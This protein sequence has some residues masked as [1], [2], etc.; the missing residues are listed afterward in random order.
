MGMVAVGI[1]RP[2]ASRG[3]LIKARL[4]EPGFTVLRLGSPADFGKFL[5]EETEKWSKVI[6]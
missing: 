3:C 4:A 2:R 6:K 1:V 5:V